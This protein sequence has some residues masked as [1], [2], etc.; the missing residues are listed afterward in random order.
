MKGGDGRNGGAGG[1]LAI[2]YMDNFFA[3]NYYSDGGVG[4][5]GESGAAGTV[6]TKDNSTAD[7]QKT[8][9]IYNREGPG[10]G[11]SWEIAVN[12]VYIEL[13]PVKGK[14]VPSER[15]N[16]SSEREFVLRAVFF[17]LKSCLNI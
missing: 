2:S 14:T 3:G 7:G 8:L 5:G 13:F 6:Y 12:P 4:S 11:F 10:V 15:E 1:R 17:L 16:C 9:R